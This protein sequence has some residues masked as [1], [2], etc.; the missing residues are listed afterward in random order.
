MINTRFLFRFIFRVMIAVYFISHGIH[1]TQ[2]LD[3]N[4]RLAV[5][6]VHGKLALTSVNISPYCL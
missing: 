2:E 4:T 1:L 6:N 3:K 5:N